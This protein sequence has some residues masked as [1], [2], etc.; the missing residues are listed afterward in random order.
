MREKKGEDMKRKAIPL[1]MLAL[2]ILT[3]GIP[4]SAQDMG[5][6][7][8]MNIE[9]PPQ[10]PPPEG[11]WDIINEE[12]TV[13][14]STVT[15]QKISTGSGFDDYR[16]YD[17]DFGWTHTFDPTDKKIQKV[18][19]TIKAWDVNFLLGERDKVTAD[20]H[21]LGY[22]V[23]I[24]YFWTL[25][26]FSVPTSWLSDD[27]RLNM[28]LNIDSGR[29]C[30]T[31]WYC[32]GVWFI[33]CIGE[34]KS[35]RVCSTQWYVQVDYSEME[36]TWEAVAKPPPQPV[37]IVGGPYTADEGSPIT[38]DASSSTDAEEYRWNVN[39]TWTAWSSDPT[40]IY[41]WCDDYIGPVY[42][43]AKTD[44][45]IDT[46]STTVEVSNVDP[47]VIAGPDETIVECSNVS[48]VGQFTDPGM[49]DTHTVRWDFGDGTPPEEYA[50]TKE[51]ATEVVNATHYYATAGTYNVKLEVEDDDGG[52][53]V[54]Y[55]TVVVT[56]KHPTPLF[57]DLLWIF[58]VGIIASVIMVH[59]QR[60]KK[61][62]ISN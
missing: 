55:L 35:K 20:G 36:V 9:G 40:T 24:A 25:T 19:I 49:C 7:A 30:R 17:E 42:A 15:T 37:A 13:G 62:P 12:Y 18:K 59:R 8:C 2:L 47:A 50:V 52:V 5:C 23:G 21:T 54:D 32:D 16:R 29:S 27:G 56:P 58:P 6:S 14:G 38:F 48:L 31:V 28:H 44:N 1:I 51:N 11:S 60:R 10:E 57:S 53:G 26:T 39:G 3:M 4:A 45:V 34:W 33:V 61:P 46:G 41:T 43:E 22:L